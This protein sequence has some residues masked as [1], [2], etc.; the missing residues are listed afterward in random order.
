MVVVAARAGEERPGHRRVRDA[1]PEGIDVEGPRPLDVADLEMDVP[2]G[3]C[4]FRGVR[5]GV[6]RQVL[7]EERVG[8]EPDR[9]HLDLTVGEWPHVARS[10]ST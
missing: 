1:E 9:I 8:V 4:E 7:T 3:A 10:R 2:D 6:G 5:E